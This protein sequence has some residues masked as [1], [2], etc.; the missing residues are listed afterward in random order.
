MLIYPSTGERSLFD[1]DINTTSTNPPI[2]DIAPRLSTTARL[3]QNLTDNRS[4]TE[5]IGIEEFV[6]HLDAQAR[7]A[8]SQKR[9][10]FKPRT[11]NGRPPAPELDLSGFIAPTRKSIQET[12]TY[13]STK[14]KSMI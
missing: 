2:P 11:P 9:V 10:S 4:G 14:A 7:M 8:A 1:D 5:T 3:F 12:I 6:R 13:T